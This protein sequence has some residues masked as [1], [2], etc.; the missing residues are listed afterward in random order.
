[1]PFLRLL[2]FDLPCFF[3]APFGGGLTT[4]ACEEE[5]TLPVPENVALDGAPKIA[6]CGEGAALHESPLEHGGG[7]IVALEHGAAA[8]H[9][10]ASY[11]S[12]DVSTSC[13]TSLDAVRKNTSSP[14]SLASR[15]ADSSAD[16]PEETNDTQ[17]SSPAT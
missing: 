15:K 9:T 4:L 16:V 10:C 6:G 13:D 14:V 12:S 3:L 5:E 7:V 8:E 2:A 11:T 17:P 1:L